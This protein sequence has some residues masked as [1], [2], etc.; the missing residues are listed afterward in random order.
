MKVMDGIPFTIFPIKEKKEKKMKTKQYHRPQ[1]NIKLSTLDPERGSFQNNPEC[2][3]LYKSFQKGFCVRPGRTMRLAEGDK[4]RHHCLLGR[5][6][7]YWASL[8]AQR[9]KHL[10]GMWEIGV[11]S[12]GREDPLEKEMKLVE[13]SLQSYSFSPIFCY[14]SSNSSELWNVPPSG[15]SKGALKFS[16]LD[17]V[18]NK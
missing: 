7:K 3:C 14:L 11:Q 17:P 2:L 8:L 18:P 12:L 16:C 10:P 1:Q 6:P 13:E 4:E 9:L 15:R 5:P